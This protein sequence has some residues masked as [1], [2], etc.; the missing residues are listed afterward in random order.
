MVELA[1]LSSTLWG[2]SVYVL[3]D[4]FKLELL[5][6]GLAGRLSEFIT[7]AQHRTGNDHHLA[8]VPV[9]ET[10]L[11]LAGEHVGSNMSDVLLIV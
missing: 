8:A 7:G 11:A 2:L 9:I 3:R 4:V 1:L 6:Q 5:A 10:M